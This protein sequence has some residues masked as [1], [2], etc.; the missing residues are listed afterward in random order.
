MS[1]VEHA[2]REA[3]ATTLEE[4]AFLFP[5]DV[6][7]GAKHKG[8]VDAVASINFRGPFDGRLVLRVSGDLLGTIAGN[9][10]GDDEVHPEYHQRDALGELANVICGNLLPAIGGASA[11]FTLDAPQVSL[12]ELPT[13]EV[14]L[15]QT[16]IALE[17]GHAELLL[18]L[19]GALPS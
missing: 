10:F 12:L 9:M 14:P 8:P 3:A 7:E 19:T 17:E 18:Y 2:L 6:Q 5:L 4:L 1:R 13:A 16:C 15:A 11:V